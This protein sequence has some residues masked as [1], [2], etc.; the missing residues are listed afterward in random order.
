[1]V[2]L[3]IPGRITPTKLWNLLPAPA[4][5]GLALRT[6]TQLAGQWAEGYISGSGVRETLGKPFVFSPSFCVLI[7]GKRLN[8]S[9]PRPELP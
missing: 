4:A 3:V 6:I 2:F 9:M 8:K 5:S 7:G 1:M